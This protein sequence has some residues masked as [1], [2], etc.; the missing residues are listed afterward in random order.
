[1][2]TGNS[3]SSKTPSSAKMEKDLPLLRKKSKDEQ[4]SNE[5][6]NR[7]ID[8]HTPNILKRPR[9]PTNE[10]ELQKMTL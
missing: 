10:A 4:I 2:Q 8:L 1:M 3:I 7:K 6:R 9:S 5:E